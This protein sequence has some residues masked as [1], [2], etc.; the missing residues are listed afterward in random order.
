MNPY[1]P[2]NSIARRLGPAVLVGI[3]VFAIAAAPAR[4]CGVSVS[5][6]L[7]LTG[8]T[9][10]TDCIAV[11]AAGRIYIG[12]GATLVLTGRAGCTSTIDG[13]VILQT[14]SSA[15][16]IKTCDHLFTGS[17][18]IVGRSNSATIRQAAG[19][20]RQLTI[21]RK[22]TV[23]GALKFKIDLVNNGLV[24]ADDGIAAGSRDTI[25]LYSGTFTGSGEWRVRRYNGT[26]IATLKIASGAVATALAG[27]IAVGGSALLDIDE[28]LT[29]SGDLDFTGGTIEVAPGKAFT[30]G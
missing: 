20:T 21:D 6:T 19:Q 24:W 9:F 4:A 1:N 18:E 28:D 5:G 2:F 10:T 15:L 29:T 17:G 7:T 22:L 26:H 23:R 14:A 16:E 11:Q 25:E 30:A 8:A 13:K 3:A 12:S 27:P